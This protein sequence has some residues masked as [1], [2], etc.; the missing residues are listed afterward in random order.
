MRRS[1][2]ALLLLLGL[3]R[4]PP[5]QA[6]AQLGIAAAMTTSPSGPTVRSLGAALQLAGEY[7][8]GSGLGL[9]I[10][11]GASSV[12]LD[13][14]G[15]AP[16]SG[17][18]PGNL[19]LG[20]SLERWLHP[21]LEGQA[22]VRAGA[23]LALYPGGIDDNRLAELAYGMAASA[24]GFREPFLWQPNVVPVIVGARA[25][26]H[27]LGWLTLGA[28][29]EPAWLL[30]VNQRP[31]RWAHAAQLEAAASFQPFVAQ[32]GLTHFASTL[33]LENRDRAQTALRGGAGALVHGQRVVL[34]VSIGLDGP[35][36]ALQSAPHPWWGI[37]VSADL[38]WG[39]ELRQ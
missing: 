20:L 26:L 22:S 1:H 38:S 24:H 5:A 34:D 27:A 17:T 28:Q 39:G 4:P 29:L 30:S 14:E 7:R 18:F 6:Q 32:L 23:P 16:R 9:S 25:R 2:S 33:P 10:A 35:Y 3:C 13:I 21:G 31:S 12:A 8:F 15:Q 37:G 36:G 11:G 19:L